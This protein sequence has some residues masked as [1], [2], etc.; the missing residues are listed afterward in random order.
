MALAGLYTHIGEYVT[1]TILTKKASPMFAEIHNKRKRQ[2]IIL[3]Q[4][5]EQDWLQDDLNESDVTELINLQFND[6]EL[7]AYTVSKDL[8]SPRVNSDID[9]ITSKVEYAELNTLF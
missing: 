5:N 1:F 7:E 8:F 2:P 3:K 6:Y 4:E 9:I